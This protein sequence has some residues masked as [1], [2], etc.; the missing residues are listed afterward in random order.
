MTLERFEVTTVEEVP[1]ENGESSVQPKNHNTDKTQPEVNDVSVNARME[2]IAAS[3]EILVKP[4][5]L[6]L[7]TGYGAE[8]A[9]RITGLEMSFLDILIEQ[10]LIGLAIWGFLFL[11]IYFNYYIAYKKG[12]KLT[13][14]DI[15]LMAA[16][17]GILLLTNINPFINN[18]IGISFFLVLLVY[19]QSLKD[20]RIKEG[21]Q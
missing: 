6:I 12:Y 7:G 3:K 20:L 1:S 16:F 14:L 21:V 17:M 10:G 9:G 13:T 18:P 8:I 5:N 11:V 2:F 19:S 15:S 4:V